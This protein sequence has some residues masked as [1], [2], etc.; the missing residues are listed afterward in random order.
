MCLMTCRRCL[1]CLRAVSCILLGYKYVYPDRNVH[2]NVF[3]ERLILYVKSRYAPQGE[4]YRVL[5]HRGRF[6][7]PLAA[8]VCMFVYLYVCVWMYGSKDLHIDFWMYEYLDVI[9][10]ASI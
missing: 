8:R 9:S 1:S 7:E 6:D 4:L 2:A 5:T 3:N 10:H